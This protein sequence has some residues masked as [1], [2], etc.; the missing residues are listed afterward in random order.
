MEG[1]AHGAQSVL[2]GR[3]LERSP[4]AALEERREQAVVGPDER[5]ALGDDGEAAAGGA[6]A[7]IDDREM[8]R[9]GGQERHGRPP[10]PRPLG[11]AVPPPL[12]TYIPEARLARDTDGD[13]LH[14]GARTLHP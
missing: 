5:R 1:A 3:Q 9:A 7:G 12:V 2:G 13:T 4:L 11:P 14:S 8:H 10:R 6:D